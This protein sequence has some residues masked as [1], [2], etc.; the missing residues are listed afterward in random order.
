MGGK[1]G[2][3]SGRAAITP[4]ALVSGPPSFLYLPVSMLLQ[5][6]LDVRGERPPILRCELLQTAA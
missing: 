4:P 2:G 1:L 5:N 6:N 3:R